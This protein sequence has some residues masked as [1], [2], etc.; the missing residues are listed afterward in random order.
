[1]RTAPWHYTTIHVARPRHAATRC[2]E[3]GEPG[4]DRRYFVRGVLFV[5]WA[6]ATSTSLSR[7][8]NFPPPSFDALAREIYGE[9]QSGSA[10]IRILEIGAGLKCSSVF[11]NRFRAE[12]E[13]TA[14]DVERPDEQTLR[15]AQDLAARQGYGFTFELGDATRLQYADASFDCV[16]CSLTLCSVPSVEAGVAEVHRVLKPGGRFGFVEHVRSTP[17]DGRPVLALSQKLLDP[18]QQAL[19]HNCHLQ[20]D[21]SNMIVAAF[22]GDGRVIR[23]E[24]R[25]NDEMWPVSQLAAG[26]VTKASFA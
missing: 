3:A 14:I 22:G 16:V 21:T 11:G 20:R 15:A 2:S 5:A 19:A 4:L 25:L 6:Y 7:V 1:M 18:A 23:L 17:A 8:A 13:V 24:R 10:P 26:V 12:S 9:A